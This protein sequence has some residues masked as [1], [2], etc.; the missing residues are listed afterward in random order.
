M[1]DCKLPHTLLF[2]NLFCPFLH[3]RPPPS[4]PTARPTHTHTHTHTLTAPI[5]F[6]AFLPLQLTVVRVMTAQYSAER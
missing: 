6:S 2:E 3:P 1:A 5:S 4:R